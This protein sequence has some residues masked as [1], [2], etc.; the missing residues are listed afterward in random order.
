MG[1]CRRPFLQ[2]H[3]EQVGLRSERIRNCP[4]RKSRTCRVSTQ[5]SMTLLKSQATEQDMTWD[6]SQDLEPI[7]T[8]SAGVFEVDFHDFPFGLGSA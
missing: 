7:F 8:G 5:S 1:L 6:F 4:G 2:I 3:D